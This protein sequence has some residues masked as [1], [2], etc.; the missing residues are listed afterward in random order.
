MKTKNY[1]KKF[2]H[3]SSPFN[4]NS[5]HNDITKSK[6]TTTF[7]NNIFK[8]WEKFFK[9]RMVVKMSVTKKIHIQGI[10]IISFDDAIK[11]ALEETALTIDH[12]FNLK[13]VGLYC[14]IKDKTVQEYIADTEISFKI[15]KENH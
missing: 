4:L 13:V 8:I 7:L 6:K 14:N 15:D 10:S 3:A 12:I 1:K 5:Q 9:E 11:N 2:F